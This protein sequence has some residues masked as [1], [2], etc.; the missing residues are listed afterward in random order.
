[1]LLGAITTQRLAERER[2][3]DPSG[4]WLCRLC[5]VDACGRDHGMCPSATSAALWSGQVSEPS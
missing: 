1:M 3:H 5:D 2:G 4:G